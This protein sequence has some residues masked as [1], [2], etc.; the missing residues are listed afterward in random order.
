MNKVLLFLVDFFI[1]NNQDSYS[2]NVV[3]LVSVVAVMLIAF[4]VCVLITKK[5]NLYITT[6]K[7]K[8]QRKKI[9]DK[10]VA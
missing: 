6:T 5:N 4:A 1:S 10:E 2:V 8:E 3:L 9:Q 7:P